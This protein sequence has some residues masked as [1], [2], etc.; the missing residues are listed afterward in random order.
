MQPAEPA[1]PTPATQAGGR[2]MLLTALLAAGIVLA[3][4][5]GIAAV[6]TLL[7][8]LFMGSMMGP[9]GYCR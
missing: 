8:W 1:R 6:L 9:G 3:A 5:L 2:S 7:G 4:L